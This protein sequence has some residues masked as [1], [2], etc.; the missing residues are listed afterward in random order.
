MRNY[1]WKILSVLLVLFSIIFGLKTPLS[2]GIDSVSSHK[3]TYGVNSI[4]ITGY[5]THFADAAQSTQVWLQNG[6]K[7]FC[8]YEKGIV[9]NTEMRVSFSFSQELAEPFFDLYINNDIDGTFMLENAFMQEGLEVGLN[10]AGG[11]D[12]LQP[13][14]VTENTNFDF[15]NQPILNETIRNLFFHVP[16]WFAM[17]TIMTLS[18]VFSIRYLRSADFK[19][20]V[21]AGDA[22]SVGILFGIMG[23]ATGSVWARFTWGAWWISDPRLNGAVLSV[24]IY[25]A[26]FVLKGSVNDE[27]KSARIGA[28]YNIFA[29]AMLILFIM[30]I[31]RLTDSLHPGVGGN[32]AFNQYDLDDNM[33]LVFYPAVLG[34]IG[35]SIWLF[36]VK[37]RISRLRRSLYL[38]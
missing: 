35:M 30:I 16:I 27:E 6:E 34:W 3:I 21:M 10:T 4:H 28:V 22:A 2:P 5:N 36:S 26:Y 32:P 12:C 7:T 23:L 38:K 33:R 29:Y 13:I 19:W 31:P 14:S 15:P 20:N 37:N 25:L 11:D 9:N 17:L 1:W 24:L 8:A 18:L